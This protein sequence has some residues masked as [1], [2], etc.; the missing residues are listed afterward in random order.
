M[1]I[2]FAVCYLSLAWKCKHWHTS[3]L[4]LSCNPLR[5]CR[6]LCCRACRAALFVVA[7]H[8]GAP[9]LYVVFDSYCR[10]C[11]V[12]MLHGLSCL[13]AAADAA[14]PPRRDAWRLR[15]SE[16]TGACVTEAVI[17]S[18][19]CSEASTAAASECGKPHPKR[20][21]V[22]SKQ[23]PHAASRKAFALPGQLPILETHSSER[24][25]HNVQAMVAFVQSMEVW[26]ASRASFDC[27]TC[28]KKLFQKLVR[29]VSYK[30]FALGL[31]ATSRRAR[32][33]NKWASHYVGE[34][35]VTQS[36]MT[37]R[38]IVWLRSI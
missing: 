24:G 17:L 6:V 21:R 37:E 36:M 22:T 15:K 1:N 38:R 30:L 14:M 7:L 31:L 5:A 3:R 10:Q 29:A 35:K 28:A 33:L 27:S 19:S 12:H 18:T 16:A 13:V 32:M 9:K 11:I 20:R 8:C 4:M 2:C 25:P 34:H 26:A 23:S